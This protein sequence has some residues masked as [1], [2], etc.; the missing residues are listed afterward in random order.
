MYLL[1]KQF[2]EQMPEMSFTQAVSFLASGAIIFGGIIPFVPQYLEIKRT[3][4]ADGFSTY[5]CLTLLIANILRVLFW[6]GH[7]FELPLLLQSAVMMIVMLALIQLCTAVRL[8]SE[9]IAN[10]AQSFTDFD[11]QY[12]WRWTNFSSYVQFLL[13]F[14]LVM[15][16]LTYLLRE[17]E[18][19]VEI[20]GFLAVFFEAMLGSPQFYRNFKNKSTK[21]MSIQMVM[22]WTLGDMFKTIYFLL[23]HA[24]IQ[25]WLCGSLQISLDLC[26]LAQVVFYR[27]ARVA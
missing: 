8:Q 26:I 14:T 23:R 16:W 11:L 3:R 9:I 27:H 10:K 22:L 18:V 13:S 20:I 12:F 25:F 7:P 24:P 17:V 19:Y 2:L 15:T 5:V 21:G 4:N 1:L 6:F